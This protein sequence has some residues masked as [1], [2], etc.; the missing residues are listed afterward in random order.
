VAGPEVELKTSKFRRPLS[1]VARGVGIVEDSP[2]RVRG[3]NHNLVGL[4]IMAKLPGCNEYSIKKLMRLRIP[5][6]C[7]MKDLTDIVDQLL[8]SLD[9]ASG[10]GSFSLSWGLAGP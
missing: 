9:F 1:D 8:D 2:Q 5:G 3:Y 4:K 7:F 10:T 6:L